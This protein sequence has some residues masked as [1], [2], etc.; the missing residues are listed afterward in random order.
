MSDVDI[1]EMESSNR[2]SID[3]LDFLSFGHLTY[4]QTCFLCLSPFTFVK[5]YGSSRS[6]VKYFQSGRNLMLQNVGFQHVFHGSL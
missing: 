6:W 3:E 5:I 4:S 2:T 1:D